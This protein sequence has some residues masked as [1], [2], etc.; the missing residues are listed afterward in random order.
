MIQEEFAQF[1]S[2]KEAYGRE[3]I[4]RID[5]VNN[6][7]IAQTGIPQ[8]CSRRVYVGHIPAP[9][10]GLNLRR[11]LRKP[12]LLMPIGIVALGMDSYNLLRNDVGVGYRASACVRRQNPSPPSDLLLHQVRPVFP[13]R[14]MTKSFHSTTDHQ[15][16][17]DG[18]TPR[19]RSA[20]C[21]VVGNTIATVCEL[22]LI[23]EPI[24]QQPPQNFLISFRR[25]D[26]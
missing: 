26:C 19:E 14:L 8:P 3:R 6:G 7:F 23:N 15:L 12:G 25:L 9:A 11:L 13:T 2:H 18:S 21:F 24:N 1:V 10:I 17:L 16:S 22:L 5:A 20:I 4:R